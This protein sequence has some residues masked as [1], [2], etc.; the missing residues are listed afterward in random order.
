M[1]FHG[2]APES[3][4][5]SAGVTGLASYSVRLLDSLGPSPDPRRDAQSVVSLGR[6]LREFRPHVVHTH[7]A[8][9]GAVGRVAVR[10]GFP[11]GRPVLI[12]TYHG[13]VLT[14]YFGRRTSIA[15]RHIERGLARFTDR[16]VSPSEATAN[17]LVSLGVGDWNRFEVI[18]HGFDLTPFTSVD[19]ASAPLRNDLGLSD[20]CTLVLYVGRLA[21]IKRVDVLLRAIG[22]LKDLPAGSVH[23]AIA[24]EGELTAELNKLAVELDI[25]DRVTFLGYRS[26]VPLLAAAADIAVLASDNEGLPIALIEAAAACLPTVATRVGGVPEAAPAGGGLLFPSGDHQAMARQLRR[27]IADPNMR[28][29]MGRV[30]QAYVLERF[31]YSQLLDRTEWLYRTLVARRL[32]QSGASPHFG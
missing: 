19:K 6:A 16:F 5:S 12:H 10:A 29:E 21:R 17:E 11:R 27:L 15:Y 1:L 31:S 3:E 23:V 13:H 26:D 32:Y 7:T 30:G 20:E 9:A 25:A 28:A 14:G 8:K 22:Q 4:P 24:G 18:P 2:R